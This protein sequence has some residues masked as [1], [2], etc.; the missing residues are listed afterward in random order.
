MKIE[1]E[2]KLNILLNASGKKFPKENWKSYPVFES[3]T[4]A[5]E[6]DKLPQEK[7]DK[8]FNCEEVP[9]DEIVHYGHKLD[10]LIKFIMEDNSMYP[11]LMQKDELYVAF[12]DPIKDGDISVVMVKDRIVVRIVYMHGDTVELTAEN[13]DFSTETYPEADVTFLGRVCGYSREL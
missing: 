7:K 9:Y 6:F 4:A 13:S 12:R 2:E 8:Y 5:L 11:R 1:D 10:D 3:M